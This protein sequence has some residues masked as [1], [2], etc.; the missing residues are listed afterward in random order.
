MPRCEDEG[1]GVGDNIPIVKPGYL[2]REDDDEGFMPAR[3][4]ETI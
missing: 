3:S 1:Y 4:I 2:T